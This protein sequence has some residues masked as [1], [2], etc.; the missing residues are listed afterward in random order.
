LEHIIKYFL[1]TILTIITISFLLLY[2]NAGNRLLI[3]HA[4]SY[5]TNQ[6][7][8]K[9]QIKVSHLSLSLPNFEIRALLNGKTKVESKGTFNPFNQSFKLNYKLI[10]PNII[11]QNKITKREFYLTGKANGTM[12]HIDFFGK[13]KIFSSKNQNPLATIELKNGTIDKNSKAVNCDYQFIVDNLSRMTRKK[14]H[15]SLN[16][17]GKITYH[18][19]IQ[20][21]GGA[22]NLGGYA[23]FN[24]QND[25]VNVKLSSVDSQKLLY[26]LDYP[27]ALDA[28][29]NGTINYHFTNQK[30]I[31]DLAMKD[32]N[33]LNC[34]TTQNIYNTLN[35]DIRKSS[36]KYGKF[37]ANVN[38]KKL[39]CDFK[40]QNPNSHLYLTNTKIDQNKKTIHANFDMKMQNKKLS[41]KLYGNLYEPNVQINMGA[42]LAFKIKQIVR[43]V[44][45]FD[46]KSKFD[47]M[48]DVAEGLFG[49]FF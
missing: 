15:G 44:T 23:Y 11:C 46:M 29:V 19:G 12:K 35:L 21:H 27:P 14:Y 2:T 17:L 30:A 39:N 13:G 24:Y 38:Q 26:L 37:I 16:I 43:P 36:F 20:I 7:N 9:L 49:G 28:K 41:G 25:V 22:E 33:F 45:N 8:N 31:I 42:L 3:P 10:T 32:I 18:K 4:S 40:I 1:Y 34:I 47:C 48:N 5:L 6:L